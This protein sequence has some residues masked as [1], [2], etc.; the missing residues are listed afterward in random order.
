MKIVFFGT[1]QFAAEI[2]KE[3]ILH[4]AEVIAVVT[5]PDRP[6]GRSGTALPPPVK[7]IASQMC[8]DIPLYQPE[9]A[10]APEFAELLSP[11]NADLFV[12]AAYGEIIK[13]NLLDMPRQGCINVHGSILPKYRGAAPIQRCLINGEVETGITI[14]YM[15]RKMDAGDIIKI[16]KTPIDPDMTAGDLEELLHRLGSKALIEVIGDLKKGILH[17]TPQNHDEATM[18]PKL[19]LEDC[20]VRWDR[21]AEELHNLIRG[22]TPAPGAWCDVQIR[23]AKKKVKILS[24]RIS[25]KESKHPSGQILA[26]GNE[27][28]VIA[29]GQGSIAILSLQA[30][31][32]KA[33][34]AAE[35]CRG[36]PREAIAFSN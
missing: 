27:G 10:S 6:K 32:K 36:V 15:V 31:G 3:L 22:V 35:F 7:V 25:E 33:M 2:L 8:P 28:I 21:P 30:E 4:R 24:T 1:S 14:M 11:L 23:G 13:Q 5:R 17:R 12:V 29:C 16:V 20:E 18:A 19:E 34:S 9:V 26:Y